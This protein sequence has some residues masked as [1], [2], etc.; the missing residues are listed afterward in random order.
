MR[1]ISKSYREGR[2]YN[3]KVRITTIMSEQQFLAVDESQK[4]LDDL[5][6]AALETV[7]PSKSDLT[8]K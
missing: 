5:T 4:V 1:I 2:Y 7:L 3:K 6:E 8:T